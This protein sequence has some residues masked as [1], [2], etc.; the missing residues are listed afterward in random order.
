MT[1][2]SLIPQCTPFSL[3]LLTWPHFDIET[4]I[5]KLLLLVIMCRKSGFT[6]S[7]AG[8]CW[9]DLS[10]RSAPWSSHHL[11][12][13]PFPAGTSTE[14]TFRPALCDKKNS[15]DPMSKWLM[16]CPNEQRQIRRCG[17]FL[18]CAV[19]KK[20]QNTAL[21]WLGLP[22]SSRLWV[23]YSVQCSISLLVNTGS[24]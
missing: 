3:Y 16:K 5:N 19:L 23:E 15:S 20:I 6:I 11:N 10:N 8:R 12:T 7:S 24:G 14:R 17:L 4:K 2:L 9:F 22:L 18:G 21:N 1:G 13:L